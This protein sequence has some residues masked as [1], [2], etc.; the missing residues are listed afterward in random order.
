MTGPLI[1]SAGEALSSSSGSTV[2]TSTP[3]RQAYQILRVA[4]VLSREFDS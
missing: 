3:S 1:S 2:A 4:F